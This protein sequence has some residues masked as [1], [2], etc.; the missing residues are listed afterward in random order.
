MQ[1]PNLYIDYLKERQNA[2]VLEH[3]HG[4]FVYTFLGD[5]KLYLQDMYVEPEHRRT[6]VSHILFARLLKIAKEKEITTII[7]STDIQ[8]NNA[9]AGLLAALSVGFKITGIDKNMIWYSK[10]IN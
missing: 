8:A 6:G 7:G 10:E 2:E 5:G 9:E 4:L 1:L 3:E